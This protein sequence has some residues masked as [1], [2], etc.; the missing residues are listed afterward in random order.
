MSEQM[1]VEAFGSDDEVTFKLSVVE[2]REPVEIH[3]GTTSGEATLH[4]A[5]RTDIQV[6][7]EIEGN[8]SD[9]KVVTATW[10]G[11]RLDIA[12]AKATGIGRVLRHHGNFD[13]RVEIPRSLLPRFGGP[14]IVARLN[15]ASGEL[16]V[17]ELAG[18]IRLA[19]AS[20]G[21]SLARLDGRVEC[22]T[23]SGD[24]DV[25]AIRGLL[26][27]SAVSGDI[28]LSDAILDRWEI[29]TV[30]GG[31]SGE[32]VLTGTGPYRIN[33]VSGDTELHVGVLAGNGQPDAFMVEAS[34]MS[35]DIEV[36]G[37]AR[38]LGKQRWQIGSG[39]NP[40]GTI[41]LTSVS[42][43]AS[44]T[45]ESTM[46]EGDFRAAGGG[47]IGQPWDGGGEPAAGE[48]TGRGRTDR[49]DR[50]IGGRIEQTVNRAI[51]KVDWKGIDRSI[52]DALSNAFGGGTRSAEPAP[53]PAPTT[54]RPPA[55]PS[56][57]S[58]PAAPFAEP[59][60][61]TSAVKPDPIGPA[62]SEEE[63]RLEILRQI[64][65]GELSVEDG[66]A[67]LDAPRGRDQP[68]A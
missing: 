61:G 29:N 22:Q 18:D 2:S 13:V 36:E 67:Q 24:I 28:S 4:A 38:K 41:K 21:V 37:E 47:W 46:V 35:G 59:A 48:D 23:A 5:D 40:D 66:M 7:L 11:R 53:P 51:G 9:D 62:V 20:G 63:R 42:G 31:I 19:T 43:D 57:P 65:R 26:K 30:S 34:T 10:D 49:N 32:V 17:G 6:W 44:L 12:P 50:D 8:S 25:E 15:S 68:D 52:D 3:I 60:A 56:A 54:P 1:Y 45:V 16:T 64:E 33:T 39:T 55:P 58:A 27:V 14:G